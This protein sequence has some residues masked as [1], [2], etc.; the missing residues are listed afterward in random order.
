M[1]QFKERCGGPGNKVIF[2]KA[3]ALEVLPE[4][5]RDHG[6]HGVVHLC[7]WG[8]HHHV[9]KGLSGRKGKTARRRTR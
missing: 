2:T 5:K 9:S 3:E 1:S 7:P 4:F 6:G 8:Q